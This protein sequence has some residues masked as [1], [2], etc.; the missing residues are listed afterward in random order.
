MGL[1]P[2]VSG[3]R[4]VL[5]HTAEFLRSPEGLFERGYAEHG[6]VF[7]LRVLGKPVVVLVGAAR[8]KFLFAETDRRLSIRRAY[9]FFRHMFSRDGYFLAEPAEYR[10]QREIVM[11]RF[12]ARNMDGYVAI[13]D[14]A[15]L[16]FVDGLAEQGEFDLVDTLGPRIIDIAARC[17]LGPEFGQRLSG[18]YQTFLDFS[19]GLDPLLPGWFPAPKMRRC[20]QAR[21]RIR[22]TV[23]GII[24]ERRRRPVEPPDF[25]QN[26]AEATYPDGTA[27][28]DMVLVNLALMLTW[29]A[30]ET[31]TGQLSWAVI[32]L[33]QH[34][35]Q[36]QR[37]LAEQ[38]GVLAGREPLNPRQ[39]SRLTHLEHALRETERL[40]P[41]TNGIV[42]VATEKI[43]Y[44]GHTIPRGAFVLVP[45]AAS[46][47]MPEV[48]GEPD[49][50]RP[51]R[52][53]DN[54]RLTASLVGFG[55]GMHRCLGMSFAYQ[56]MKVATTRLLQLLDLHLIDTDPQPVPG[57]KTKWPQT[58]C[59]VG[60]R[61]RHVPAEP[62]PAAGTGHR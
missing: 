53:A 3:S 43:D 23:A 22:R 20:H 11:P 29:T 55:G 13:M 6:E 4:G 9:P 60:Y 40:H 8:A 32:D 15:L 37:V 61:R 47:R 17:F 50:Y 34:P 7:T 62:Q 14:A 10:R 36:Q 30:W 57:Q 56:E 41:A 38:A 35:G 28:P 27:V 49:R 25:L 31:T 52:F 19:E 5:G 42:R 2:K 54:P 48:F 46:H 18:F 39:L 51:D 21:D 44:D 16:E 26:L 59:R 58:P 45:P 12:Q 1:P 33:L 24:A